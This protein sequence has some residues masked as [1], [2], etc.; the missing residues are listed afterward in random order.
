MTKFSDN[1]PFDKRLMLDDFLSSVDFLQD[2]FVEILADDCSSRAYYRVTSN[3]A[4]FVLMDSSLEPASYNA[5][6][7][8]ANILLKHSFN[9]P[10]VFY[11]DDEKKLVLLEDFGRYTLKSH[12]LINPE[13][14]ANLYYKAVDVLVDLHKISP[15][16]ELDVYSD[17]VLLNGL[18][19][20]VVHSYLPKIAARNNYVKA[21]EE[22][23][24][25]FRSLLRA[26][27]SAE[28]VIVLRDYH[29]ENLM[30]AEGGELGIIDFQ[31]AMN[32]SSAYDL[33]SLLE[34]ARRFVAPESARRCLSYYHDKMSTIDIEGFSTSYSILSAQR[35]LRILGLFHKF[36]CIEQR[37]K[38]KECIPRVVKYLEYRL[39]DPIL[40]DL[41]QWARTYN[42]L[43]NDEIT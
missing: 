12:L 2:P 31:D 29:S 36:G 1:V 15:S 3:K 35:N 21:G 43:Y 4:S 39:R 24:D 23:E 19:R 9:A 40:H 33:L 30:I 10:K 32:G 42:V 18:R 5:F 25:I 34:D 38:Y 20:S 28:S 22:L 7:K 26:R 11:Y 8:V 41:S 13:S 37:A 16:D 14:E 6:M 17:E 27:P